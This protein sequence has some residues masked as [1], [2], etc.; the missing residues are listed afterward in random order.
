[1][2]S[3]AEHEAYVFEEDNAY[4]YHDN[5]FQEGLDLLEAAMLREAAL[6]FEAVCF[7]RHLTFLS[8]S[9][10]VC[11]VPRER[12]VGKTGAKL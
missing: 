6:A 8:L 2:R 3:P 12:K 11:E 1:M 5:P 10:S 9:L 4:L 7:F